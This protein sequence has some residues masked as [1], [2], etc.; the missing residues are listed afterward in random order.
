MAAGPDAGVVE[1][2]IDGSPFRQQDLFTKWS[3]RLHIPFAYVLD[4]DLEEGNHVLMLRV[5]AD[6][7][8]QSKGHCARVAHLL[9]N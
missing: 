7:N 1:Y 4:A 6:R 9:V 5:S 8:P 2:S 3:P